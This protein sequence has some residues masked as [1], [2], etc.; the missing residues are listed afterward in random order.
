[1]FLSDG[2][3]DYSTFENLAGNILADGEVALYPGSDMVE[4]DQDNSLIL[5]WLFEGNRFEKWFGEI[6]LK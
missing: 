6:P 4:W 5:I 2:Q 1:L 3:K